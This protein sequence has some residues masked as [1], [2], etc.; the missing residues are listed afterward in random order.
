MGEMLWQ[1]TDP[2]S[3]KRRVTRYRLSEE[4]ARQR[5]RDP[6]KVEGSLPIAK[7]T[8]STSDFLRWPL[9]S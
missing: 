4:E 9:D 1:H 5:L 8:G 7:T 3:G 2:V 6:V